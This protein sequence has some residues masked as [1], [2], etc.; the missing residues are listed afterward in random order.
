LNDNKL[1]EFREQ[2]N[3]IKRMGEEIEKKYS[4]FNLTTGN[5]AEIKNFF[6]E[7]EKLKRMESEL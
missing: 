4:G 5:R 1:K 6:D 7:F 3:M 2:Y